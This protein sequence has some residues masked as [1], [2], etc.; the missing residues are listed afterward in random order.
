MIQAEAGTFNT[1]GEFFTHIRRILLFGSLLLD[2]VS[3]VQ[4]IYL[5]Q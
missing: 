3:T 5:E 1:A 2:S 4:Y